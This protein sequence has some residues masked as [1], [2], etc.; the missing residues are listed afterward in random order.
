[1]LFQCFK[2]NNRQNRGIHEECGS[3]GMRHI[4]KE[5]MCMHFCWIWSNF[6]LR[7]GKFSMETYY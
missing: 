5:M 6:N 7:L 1:M 3:L 4:L 2:D